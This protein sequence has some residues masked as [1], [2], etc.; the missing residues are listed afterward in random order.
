MSR[1]REAE[2]ERDRNR[3]KYSNYGVGFG[4]LSGTLLALILQ[5]FFDIQF[6]VVGPPFGTLIGLIIGIIIA[7]NKNKTK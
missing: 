6:Y 7:K 4:F 1:E 3:R 2:R 5:Y